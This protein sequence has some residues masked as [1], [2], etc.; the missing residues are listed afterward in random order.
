MTYTVVLP[1]GQ[2]AEFPDNVSHETAA[3]VIAR[4]F[5]QFKPPSGREQQSIDVQKRYADA[6]EAAAK[7]AALPPETTFGGQAK[8]L[9][10]GIIPGAVGLAETAGTGIAALLPE[11]TEKAVRGK[12]GEYAAAAKKPFEAAPGYEESVTRKLGEGLGSAIPFFALGPF[13]AAGRIAGAGLGAAAGAGEARQ[14]AEQAGACR[15]T[16]VGYRIRHYPRYV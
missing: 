9:F 14:G 6:R 10:K 3:A 15:A 12:I 13:G 4:Q 16:L 2:E 1:D 7:A 11:E 5:P 8:E